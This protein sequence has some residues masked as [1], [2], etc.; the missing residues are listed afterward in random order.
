MNST[1]HGE[2]ID[3]TT[4]WWPQYFPVS[5]TRAAS[6]IAP[7]PDVVG[8]LLTLNLWSESFLEPVMA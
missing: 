2:K 1:F 3:F 7:D 4:D 8:M 5:G 6:G